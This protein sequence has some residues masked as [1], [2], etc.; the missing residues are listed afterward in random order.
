MMDPKL[1]LS[2]QLLRRLDGA[3][4]AA[5][6]ERFAGDDVKRFGNQVY[7]FD[8]VGFQRVIG[9]GTGD[10]PLLDDIFAWFDSRGTSPVF[11]LLPTDDRLTLRQSLVARGWYQRRCQSLLYG[12][13][14]PGQDT[15]VHRSITSEV[16]DESSMADFLSAFIEAHESG[17]P[18]DENERSR[19]E[20]QFKGHTCTLF[21]VRVDGNPAGVGTIGRFS[22]DSQGIGYMTNSATCPKYRRQGVHR[23]VLNARLEWA[24]QKRLQHVAADTPVNAASQRNIMRAG[25]RL[26]CQLTQWSKVEAS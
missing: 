12:V 2:D 19:V 22:G 9:L 6:A 1:I 15:P 4:A 5:Y 21:L 7:A 23:A 17:D 26:A 18:N 20:E 10:E 16:V 24:K 3:R 8:H 13:P 25:M 14:E 11:D